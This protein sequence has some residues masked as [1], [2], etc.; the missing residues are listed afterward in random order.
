MRHDLRSHSQDLPRLPPRTSRLLSSTRADRS[1]WRACEASRLAGR[2]FGE[3][4]GR[5]TR[6]G[7]PPAGASLTFNT[8][9]GPLQ[10]SSSIGSHFTPTHLLLPPPTTPLPA[11]NVCPSRRVC[12]FLNPAPAR[13]GPSR[14]TRTQSEQ[15]R[16]QSSLVCIMDAIHASLAALRGRRSVSFVV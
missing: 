16:P 13:A 7:A 10:I 9:L 14:A 3:A 4:R 11:P 5:R 12:S 1:V 15:T 2:L 6:R 8:S